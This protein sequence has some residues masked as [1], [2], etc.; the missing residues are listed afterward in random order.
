M[1][2]SLNHGHE[3]VRQAVEQ[4]KLTRSSESN[5][6]AV[7]EECQAMNNAWIDFVRDFEQQKEELAKLAEDVE[8]LHDQIA[9]TGQWLREQSDTLQSLLPHQGTLP[10]KIEKV[11]KIQVNQSLRFSSSQERT[12]LS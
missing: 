1:Y 6:K 5:Q 12:D 10:S 11:K 2:N 3:V 8:H 7:D 4:V 9:I